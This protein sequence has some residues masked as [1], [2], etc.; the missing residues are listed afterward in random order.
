LISEKE[1][2]LVKQKLMKDYKVLSDIT[3]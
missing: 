3:A 2:T 1:Y